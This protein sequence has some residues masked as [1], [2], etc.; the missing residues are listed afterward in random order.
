MV[1]LVT[2]KNDLIK[3]V[4]EYSQDYTLIFRHSRA[5]NSGVSGG[6]WPKF[7]LIQAL[8]HVL[9]TCMNEDQIKNERTG[10]FTTVLPL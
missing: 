9:V 8:M 4:L 10:V 3:K 7:K 5:D 1:V 2:C 6:T